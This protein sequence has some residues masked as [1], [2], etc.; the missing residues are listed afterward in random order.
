MVFRSGASVRLSP[1]SGSIMADTGLRLS[2][3]FGM[4]DGFWTGLQLDHD[5]AKT[6][7]SLAETPKK[8]KTWRDARAH[9]DR[10]VQDPH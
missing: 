4:S 3:F 5:S 6:K 8:I 9:A 1:A 2:K 10:M 7:N